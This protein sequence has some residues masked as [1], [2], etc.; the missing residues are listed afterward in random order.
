MRTRSFA[1]TLIGFAA[2]AVFAGFAQADG[3]RCG[4]KLVSSGDTRASVRHKC[5]DPADVTHST[6]I[7][8]PTFVFR[9]RLYHGDEAAVE[10]E[11]WTYNFGPNKFMRRVRFVDGIV[12]DVE[13]LDYGYHDD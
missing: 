2:A 12:E 7:K 9:G 1:T 4:S 6:V 3:L 5:G 10:V 11:N 8:R 13:T